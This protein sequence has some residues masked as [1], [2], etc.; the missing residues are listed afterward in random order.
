MPVNGNIA[1]KSIVIGVAD[2][3]PLWGRQNCSPRQRERSAVLPGFLP[4]ACNQRDRREQG[5]SIRFKHPLVGPAK[6]MR[7]EGPDDRMEVILTDSTP[8]TGEPATWG[9]GQRS[10]NCSWATWASFNRRYGLLCKEKIR[11]PWKRNVEDPQSL[12]RGGGRPDG[13]GSE[14]KFRRVD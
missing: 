5:R 14:E 12:G 10:L 1:P 6:P 11:R 4:P 8:R 7:R 13:D 3:I 9:S 2:P